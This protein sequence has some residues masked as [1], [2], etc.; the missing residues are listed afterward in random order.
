MLYNQQ[1]QRSVN[2]IA[3]WVDHREAIIVT[4]TEARLQ[5]EENVFRRES[6]HTWRG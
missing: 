6:A 1:E 5:R 4:F 2:Q 3:F